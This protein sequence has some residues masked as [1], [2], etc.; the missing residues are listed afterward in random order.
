MSEKSTKKIV[1]ME[2]CST[3]W[4]HFLTQEELDERQ[5]R[6]SKSPKNPLRDILKKNSGEKF[7]KSSESNSKPGR[8]GTMLATP[9]TESEKAR[10]RKKHQE[11]LE[12]AKEYYKANPIKPI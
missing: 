4:I 5:K 3:G 9:L 1:K 2:N 10:L 6:M 7:N 11:S 12:T 8:L